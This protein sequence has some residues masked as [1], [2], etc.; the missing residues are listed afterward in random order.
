MAK[1]IDFA[2]LKQRFN[3][4]M[5]EKGERVGLAICAGL[6]VL[7]VSLGV[8]NGLTSSRP[9]V[10]SSWQQVLNERARS[11]ADGVRTA[12]L[13]QEER[14]GPKIKG[15]KIQRDPWFVVLPSFLGGPWI[16]LIE[17][18]DTKR[19]NPNIIAVD[20]SD[21]RIQMDYIRGGYQSYV[22]DGKSEKVTKLVPRAK[23][24]SGSAKL[25]T[26]LRAQHMVVVH[27]V[28]PLNEQLEEYRIALR[29]PSME[30]LKAKK[31]NLPSPLGLNV[32]RCE[33]L[34]NGQPT[35][36]TH[37]FRHN[38][39]KQVVEIADRIDAVV[40]STHFDTEMNQYYLPYLHYGLDTPLLKMAN[41]RYPRVNLDGIPL[42]FFPEDPVINPAGTT[43]KGPSMPGGNKPKD[44]GKPE[45]ADPWK[46]EFVPWST[47]DDHVLTDRFGGKYDIFDPLL[48]S[49]TKKDDK[50]A[51]E[52]AAMGGGSGG[53]QVGVKKKDKTGPA[54]PGPKIKP[55]V[56]KISATPEALVRFFDV[57]VEPGK[58]YRYCVQVRMKNPN[59]N[60]PDV[61]YRALAE[62]PELYSPYSVTPEIRIPED[63]HFYAVNQMPDRESVI[64][65][66]ADT[67]PLS[68]RNDRVP[69]QVHRWV[70]D[71][72]YQGFDLTIADWA[73]AERLLQR[74]G[75]YIGRNQVFVEVPHWSTQRDGFEIAY[76][77]RP[78]QKNR[79]TDRRATGVPVD[80]QAVPAS[81][82]VDFAG[83]KQG[84]DEIA[85]EILVL[86]PDG[87]LIVRNSRI[88]T[89]GSTPQTRERI[90]RYNVWKD[91]IQTL[92][93]STPAP[94]KGGAGGDDKAP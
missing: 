62:I 36:W 81:L 86:T 29:L 24:S 15:G 23:A 11:V 80:F 53:L 59:Y 13:S 61:A 10:G 52:E 49:A 89:E 31:E 44:S 50:V 16:A 57:D 21:K 73:I 63:H 74:R 76:I 78:G 60:H 82:I 92:R 69:V 38:P 2:A 43:S 12:Q 22:T 94:G 14:D 58:V 93:A 77:P 68:E 25:L 28:F 35:P 32:Y 33:I 51:S 19:R 48:R 8:W 83:G 47:L 87:K 75:E 3:A 34:P 85:T 45:P 26:T 90:V 55:K 27:A 65:G 20:T 37:L 88:D 5:F 9:E 56:S 39:E 18:G 17:T 40:R 30:E 67:N 7:L 6:A 64:N 41:A 42:D 91:R 4:Y 1:K 54:D 70:K 71:V 46:E 84:K 66:G 79:P 72:S